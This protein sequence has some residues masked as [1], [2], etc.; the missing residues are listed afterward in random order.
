MEI[1]VV[2]PGDSLYSIAVRF[3]LPMSQLMADNRLPDP[4]RLVV[5]QTLVLRFPVEV[6][7]VQ[8]GD[9]LTS[10]ARQS[11]L[12]L[13]QLYR[14][15]PILEGRPTLYPGQ[16]LVLR[17]RGEPGPPLLV[18]GYAYPFINEDLYRRTLPFLTFVTPFTYGIQ[19]DGSL[20]ELEDG[21]LLAA[22]RAAGTAGLMHLSTLT[23]EGNFS[24]D[25]AHLVLN[26]EAV[27]TALIGNVVSTLQAKG[28][29]GLDVD[30]EFVFPEDALPY[31]AFIARLRA[32]LTP[33]GLITVVALAPKT[34][35]EQ[36]GLLYEGHHYRAL[37]EAA[38]FAFLMTYEWGYT[39]GPPM[40]VSPLPNVRAVV[41]YAL[42]EIPAEKLW[43][44]MPNYGYDWPLPFQQGETRARSISPQ[45][46]VGL[47]A[48][49]GASIQYDETAQAPWFR[50][51]A[52]DGVEHEVWFEDARSVQAKLSLI[53]EYGL[54]GVG[55]WN[56]M[57]PFP[58][59]WLVLDSLF[60]IRDFDSLGQ[61]LRS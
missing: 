48:R 32:R 18:N 49:W 7:T 54:K 25:L 2:Q 10:V 44:G 30:F 58:Q 26:D 35:A 59:N 5:G 38:D 61:N 46:A 40:A 43:L 31:A 28:Y 21:P 60:T 47:A 11:G 16:T 4:T 27:Q 33:L 12:S 45:Y 22:A 20:V 3:G 53:P 14:N 6:L 57:R 13:R 34:W 56:L 51:T 24:N 15:N 41:E 52:E 36:P 9:T 50:Y 39:Y 42:T 29:R 19:P 37:G 55:Y 1:Y 17:Y 23:D 8:P